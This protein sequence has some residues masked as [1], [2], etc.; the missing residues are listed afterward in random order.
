[1]TAATLSF[2]H[3]AKTRS[4]LF[5][6]CYIDSP[7]QKRKTSTHKQNNGA[8]GIKGVVGR[9]RRVLH[10]EPDEGMTGRRNLI[11]GNSFDRCHFVA[12]Q[13]FVRLYRVP[14]IH[15]PP[16]FFGK[17]KL[18]PTSKIMGCAGSK[19]ALER[20]P[21]R[22]RVLRQKPD[23][24]IKEAERSTKEAF[25]FGEFNEVSGNMRPAAK[26]FAARFEDEDRRKS[27][28]VLKRK[29][30]IMEEP[31]LQRR[32]SAPCTVS[33]SYCFIGSIIVFISTSS[34]IKCI[35]TTGQEA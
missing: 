35:I 22:R 17:G 31:L 15:P 32:S 33:V 7:P 26:E 3:V 24:G 14:S 28:P 23:E 5:V 29:L 4:Y 8:C 2:I 1:M 19:E 16:L 20:V 6:S 11:V 21:S 27:A 18:T 34:N 30:S 25:D 10:Q 13:R 9:R 12:K